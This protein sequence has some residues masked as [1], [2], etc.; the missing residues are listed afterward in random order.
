VA[1]GLAERLEIQI[2]Y[3]IG[4]AEPVST[5]VNSFG[6]SKISPDK[7]AEIVKEL[8]DLRPRPIIEKL[9]LLN[10]IFKKTAVGG[11]FGRNEPGFTWE[12]LDMVDAIRKKAGI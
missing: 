3:T 11:H 10:P 8:F 12:K 4:V 6:T 1:A 9:D 2:A 5:M 7:I